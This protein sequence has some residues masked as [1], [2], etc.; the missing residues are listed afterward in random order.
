MINLPMPERGS[1]S[2]TLKRAVSAS[3]TVMIFAVPS[4]AQTV[5]SSD[6]R[7]RYT[8]SK[9]RKSSTRKASGVPHPTVEVMV[10]KANPKSGGQQQ[11]DNLAHQTARIESSPRDKKAVPPGG[12]P[13]PMQATD[14]KNPEVNF[15]FQPPKNGLKISNAGRES[16]VHHSVIN[17]R[18]NNSSR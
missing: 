3:V 6:S 13:K 1:K 11:L 7:P 4:V 8:Q 15:H 5:H 9:S 2:F 14:G 17:R 12:V 16:K 18:V 10:R